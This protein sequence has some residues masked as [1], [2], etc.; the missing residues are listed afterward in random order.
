M[1]SPNAS[2]TVIALKLNMSVNS[3]FHSHIIG[4]EYSTA[5]NNI[6]P[7]VNSNAVIVFS[8]FSKILF[9][10]PS[11]FFCKS[12]LLFILLILILLKRFL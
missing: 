6:S 11:N 9:S 4:N 5:T 10:L 2:V 7:N 3:Q 1:A 12:T 8:L